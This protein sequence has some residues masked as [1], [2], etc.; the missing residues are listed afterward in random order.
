M[1]ST[2][3]AQAQDGPELLSGGDLLHLEILGVRFAVRWG[4][5]VTQDQCDHME[6][7]WSRCSGSGGSC[8]VP[9]SPEPD[10]LVGFTASVAFQHGKYDGGAF[11][12][13][14]ASFAELVENLTSR[15]TVAAILA[16]AGDLTMLHACGVAD[17]ATGGVV[18]LVAKSGTGKT[19]AATVLART[20]GYVTD[21]TV[22]I[23][24]DGSVIPYA[25]PLSI[26]QEAGTPKQ[27]VGPD[28]L[29]LLEAPAQLVLR[30]IVLLDRV[31][32]TERVAPVLRRVPLADA[33]LA[34]IPDSSSQ[35]DLHEPLQS[36]CRLI[37]S[38]G[39]VW[40]VTYSEAADLPE[41]L[42]AL[43]TAQP[44]HEPEWSPVAGEH[45][46]LADIP[47]GFVRRAPFKDAVAVGT[48]LLVMLDSG[49]VRLSGIGP[50]IWAAASRPISR[51]ELT[52]AVREVHG[53]PEGHQA[54]VVRAVAQL[55]AAAVLLP[56][57]A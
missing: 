34:L 35:G 2:R 10:G 50:A 46:R 44:V 15:L 57:G 18:A 56:A 6:S 37:D 53:A 51:D 22:A 24:P 12:L 39:G 17:P 43:F 27:Q 16:N 33:V 48:D 45:A 55:T 21:E 9:E 1:T 8:P 31:E 23:R 54:A 32:G 11:R 52:R 28:A 5:G 30:S 13:Q 4:S 49:V 14:A 7:A 38:V 36:L 42:E 3:L 19:T 40:Q 47:K 26:K 41:A 20:Y 29:G 25:K